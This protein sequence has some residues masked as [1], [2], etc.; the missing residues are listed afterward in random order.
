VPDVLRSATYRCYTSATV[1]S[2]SQPRSLRLYAGRLTSCGGLAVGGGGRAKSTGTCN[3]STAV[4]I[5]LEILKYTFNIDL[6]SPLHL[7]EF[8]LQLVFDVCYHYICTLWFVD[9][10]CQDADIWFV[11]L[12]YNCVI[13]GFSTRGTACLKYDVMCGGNANLQLDTGHFQKPD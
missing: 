8:S 10:L 4:D 7:S 5:V 11:R 2:K 13:I 6:S 12:T 3:L 1:A 9:F